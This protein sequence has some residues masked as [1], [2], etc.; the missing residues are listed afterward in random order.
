MEREL[1]KGFPYIAV[2]LKCVEDP[3]RPGKRYCV[4]DPG[5][6]PVVTAECG[7]N[8]SDCYIEVPYEEAEQLIMGSG[9][10]KCGFIIMWEGSDQ[11]LLV[12]EGAIAHSIE[13]EGYRVYGIVSEGE[14]VAKGDR[15]AYIV[16]GKGEVRTVRSLFPGV[17]AYAAQKPESK[18]EKLLLII[19]GGEN[20][21]RARILGTQ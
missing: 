10:I 15:I 6:N 7:S 11:C 5:E 12:R 1:R 9:V 21:R 14:N 18:P 16:T 4:T 13:I 19:I 8:C 3:G 2:S 20:V 17:V